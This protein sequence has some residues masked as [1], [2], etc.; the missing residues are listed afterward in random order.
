MA[1]RCGGTGFSMKM[2][3]LTP[4]TDE[5]GEGGREIGGM[6]ARAHPAGGVTIEIGAADGPPIVRFHFSVQEAHRLGAA[7]Q[8]V[9]NG[10]GEEILLVGE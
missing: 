5:D 8:S 3:V 9:A 7:L 2:D 6:V 10:G 1:A 4:L